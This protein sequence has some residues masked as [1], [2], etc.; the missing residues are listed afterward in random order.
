[1]AFPVSL[2]SKYLQ[3]PTKQNLGAAKQILRYVASMV[4]FCNWYSKT[5]CLRLVTYTDSDW[6]GSVDDRKGTIE[7]IFSFGSGAV[8]WSSTKQE[9]VALSS[10]E[11]EYPAA[12]SAARQVL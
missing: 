10:L 9:T 11:T 8:T 7:S 6:V 3:N 12:T 2:V 5:S 1:M 4:D